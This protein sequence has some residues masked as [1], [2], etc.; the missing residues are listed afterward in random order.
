MA[1]T[2]SEAAAATGKVRST[3]FK[4]CKSGKISYVTDEHGNIQIEP[5]ELHRVYPPVSENVEG[6]VE[7]ETEKTTQNGKFNSGNSAVEQELAVLRE[8]LSGL[9]RAREDERRALTERIE[10]FRR[11]EE[12]L[13][14]DRDDLRGERDKLLRVI[15]E[16]AGS[17]KLLTDQRER[18]AQPPTP[19]PQQR[20]RLFGRLFGKRA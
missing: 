15:E 7:E 18:A 4:A 13:R 6:I 12:E 20:A 14:R 9:D 16:Q 2:L 8:R 3:I 17:V 5:A 1:Y 10:D 19:E 11:R